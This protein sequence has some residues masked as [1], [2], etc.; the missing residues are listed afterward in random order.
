[1]FD[2]PS[3]C[4]SARRVTRSSPSAPGAIGIAGGL[5]VGRLMARILE[6][7]EPF[8]P[9]TFVTVPLVLGAVALIACAV[10]A[11]GAVRIEPLAAVKAE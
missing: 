4:F 10:P 3:G 9:V 5:G 1:M 8:D 11:R 6:G 7:I 2:W